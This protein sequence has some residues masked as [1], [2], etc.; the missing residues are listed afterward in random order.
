M[1]VRANISERLQSPD[2]CFVLDIITPKIRRLGFQTE[3]DQ[4]MKRTLGYR[5]D[6][7]PAIG[8]GAR[9]TPF[10]YIYIKKKK[11]E[12]EK[13]FLLKSPVLK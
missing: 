10:C 6:V 13:F 2:A 11:K 12:K 7:S 3:R 5:S 1:C 4:S 9:Y 8:P